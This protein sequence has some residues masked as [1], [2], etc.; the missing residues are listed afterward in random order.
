MATKEE[1]IQRLRELATRLGRDPDVSGSAAEL[2]Q[3]V[4]EWEEEAEAEA[5]AEHLPA[6]ENDS[7]ES[8]VPPGIGQRSERVLIRAL[9]TLHI[10]AIDPDS[11]RELD[12]VMAGNPARISQ[13]DVD[14]L[15]AAG[16]IIEL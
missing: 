7:D 11:N 15:I 3:R 2:S 4:L 16:L 5:E 8:I 13:H 12:I 1:N 6:V 9:R 10:C 14:E